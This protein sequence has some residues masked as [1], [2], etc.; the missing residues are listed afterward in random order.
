MHGLPIAVS[1]S[2]CFPI[3]YLHIENDPHGQQLGFFLCHLGGEPLKLVSVNIPFDV[4]YSSTPYP[5]IFTPKS[6][7]PKSTAQHV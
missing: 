4:I 3:V 1:N 7:L 5:H 2:Y 6:C